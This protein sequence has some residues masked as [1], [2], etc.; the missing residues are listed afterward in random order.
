MANRIGIMKD[1]AICQIGAPFDIYETPNSRFVGD[2]IGNANMIA[3]QIIDGSGQEWRIAC[4]DLGVTVTAQHDRPMAAGL[5]V[6][7]MIRPEKIVIGREDV[8]A[9]GNRLTGKIAEIAYL[10]D[11]SIY[12][13]LLPSGTKIQV[14]QANLR[15]AGAGRLTQ[16]DEVTLSWRPGDSVVLPA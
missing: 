8:G 5:A 2:F 14:S 15:H 12:H 1:G 9:A 13:V 7:V 6:T 11:M 16:G 3:G 4:A 10:G